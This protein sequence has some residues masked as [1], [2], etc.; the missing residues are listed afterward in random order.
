[1]FGLSPGLPRLLFGCIGAPGVCFGRGPGFPRRGGF[2]F[3][4][5]ELGPQ[6]RE[7]VPLP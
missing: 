5:G 6:V 4:G 7:P 2:R 1:L 3:R